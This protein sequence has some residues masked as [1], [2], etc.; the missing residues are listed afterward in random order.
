MSNRS[1]LPDRFPTVT[2]AWCSVAEPTGM[3]ERPRVLIVDDEPRAAKSLERLVRRHFDVDVATSG[4][5]A[6]EKLECFDPDVVVTD[7]RMAKLSGPELLRLV[8][9]RCPEA[10]RVLMSAWAELDVVETAIRDNTANHYLA[11]PFPPGDLLTAI[12]NLLD[13]RT[14]RRHFDSSCR[15]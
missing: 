8:R 13:E 14:L 7:C 11:K 3:E 6:L 5:E 15:Q 2:P 4:E 9:K 1:K 12:R 10:L